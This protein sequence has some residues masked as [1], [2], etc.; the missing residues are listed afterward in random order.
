VTVFSNRSPVQRSA[1]APPARAIN[2]NRRTRR[3]RRL[4]RAD[5]HR[6]TRAVLGKGFNFQ[7]H[8]HEPAVAQFADAADGVARHTVAQAWIFRRSRVCIGSEPFLDR[9]TVAAAVKH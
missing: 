6:S 9:K 3:R 1:N 7:S 4:S 5:D 2:K 8:C